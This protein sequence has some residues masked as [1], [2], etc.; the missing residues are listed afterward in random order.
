LQGARKFGIDTACCSI[1]LGLSKPERKTEIRSLQISHEE[2]C[3][4]D[5]RF[6]ESGIVEHRMKK[7]YFCEVSGPEVGAI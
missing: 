7:F 2:N 5:V 1:D 3:S 4:V 6:G